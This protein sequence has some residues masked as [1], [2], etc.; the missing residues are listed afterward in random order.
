MRYIKTSSIKNLVKSHGRRIGKDAPTVLDAWVEKK[1]SA[2][3]EK[4]N[5]GKPIDADVMN[6]VLTERER[7]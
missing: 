5:G 7:F 2:A 3:V 4:H 1:V 6:F